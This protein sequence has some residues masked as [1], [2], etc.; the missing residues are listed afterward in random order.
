M[1]RFVVP[2]LILITFLVVGC[3]GGETTD[4]TTPT[5][6]PTLT[7]TSIS[8]QATTGDTVKVHY[9]G[10]LDDGTV[11][12]SSRDRE[13]YEFTIGAGQT[14]IGFDNAV[15]GMRLGETKTVMITA[16]EAYGPYHEGLVQEVSRDNLPEGI[17]PEVG[18]QLESVQ[19]DGRIINLTI[20]ELS[21]TTVTLDAN[22]HLAGKDLTFEIEL[23]EIE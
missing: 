23:V 17:E 9:T 10:T 5:P 21:E 18:M 7:P 22:H 14:I 3:N 8:R 16:D 20:I 19:P 13:P 6:T 1:M 12:D 11:F 2:L 15:N 4:T